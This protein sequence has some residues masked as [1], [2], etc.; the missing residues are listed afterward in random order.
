MLRILL[1]L[2]LNYFFFFFFILLLFG[3]VSLIFFPSFF[4]LSA[5]L[6]PASGGSVN[7]LAC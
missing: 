2:L 6:Y 1:I 5:W 7:S 3:F 4:Y